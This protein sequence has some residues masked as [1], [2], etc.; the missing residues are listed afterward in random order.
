M[1]KIF[2]F[3]IILL[4]LLFI[5]CKLNSEL[6]YK[7]NKLEEKDTIFYNTSEDVKI[8]DNDVYTLKVKTKYNKDTLNVVDY[9]EDKY[10]SPIILEQSLL[11]FKNDTV[12]KESKIP[13]ETIRKK[14]IKNRHLNAL[15][16][17][18]YELGLIKSEDNLYYIIMGADYCNGSNC[19][20]FMGIYSAL[21]VVIY[22]STSNKN[23]KKF[24]QIIIKHKLDINNRIQTKEIEI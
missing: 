3:L 4:F 21:G 15:R 23:M 11:F 24:E 13:I 7:E 1:I 2:R 18:I 22:E 17:P 14:T 8:I 16:T 5:S 6:T 19:L 10:S 20:E 9:Q 12:I